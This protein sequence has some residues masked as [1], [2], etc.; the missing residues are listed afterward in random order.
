MFSRSI[1]FFLILF[2]FVLAS[3]AAPSPAESDSDIRS[4]INEYEEFGYLTLQRAIDKAF[5]PL[6]N[7]TS[8][9]NPQVNSIIPRDESTAP[10]GSVPFLFEQG[11]PVL[12]IEIGTPPQKV[13]VVLDTGSQFLWVHGPDTASRNL[14]SF[15]KQ[16]STSWKGVNTT[17]HI[18]YLDAT[19][20]ILEVGKER[21]SLGA[22]EVDV[23][24]GVAK[25]T[26]LSDVTMNILGL[27]PRSFFLK[28]YLKSRRDTPMIFSFK[29]NNENGHAQDGW[30]SLG[31]YAGLVPDD[32]IWISSVTPGKHYQ[33]PLPYISYDSTK[34]SFG[35]GHSIAVDTGSNIGILP[36]KVLTSLHNKMATRTNAESFFSHVDGFPIFNL[37]DLPLE[38][39]PAVAMRFGDFEWLAEMAN[40]RGSLTSRLL[41]TESYKNFSL[42]NYFPDL[43]LAQ[44]NRKLKGKEIPSVLGSPFWSSLKGLVFDFTPGQERVGFV[45]RMKIVRKDG[46][47]NPLVPFTSDDEE[48]KRKEGYIRALALASG[49]IVLTIFGLSALGWLLYR[50]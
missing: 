15:D 31:G 34:F 25:P 5:A 39:Y 35:K 8:N 19:S 46:L 13:P 17:A 14:A 7:E 12:N 24:M 11:L 49:I 33:I 44:M 4:D 3:S 32:I 6:R 16:K 26:L 50:R 20:C 40:E 10:Q 38:M 36:G 2:F 48:A 37:T 23:S 47:I 42:P 30:F 41:T 43:F 22:N 21:V 1:F 28:E 45:P 18:Q 9:N 29:F 27:D